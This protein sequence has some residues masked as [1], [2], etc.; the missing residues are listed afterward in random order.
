MELP[1][2]FKLVTD[3]LLA[4][5]SGITMLLEDLRLSFT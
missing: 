1:T 5:V 3:S 4:M 2:D